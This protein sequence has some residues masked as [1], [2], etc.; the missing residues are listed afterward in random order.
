M[1][2]PDPENVDMSSDAEELSQVSCT[3]R[4]SKIADTDR[5]LKET[6]ENASAGVPETV[7]ISPVLEG[8]PPPDDAELL[9]D[10]DPFGTWG[11]K[12]APLSFNTPLDSGPD[13][14]EW[15]SS[16]FSTLTKKSKK[17]GKADRW[18]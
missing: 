14:T 12:A 10:S 18:A 4:R 15:P 11:Q 5:L 3:D 2:S 1:K 17:K 9:K 6:I 7:A 8:V 13:S 16:P